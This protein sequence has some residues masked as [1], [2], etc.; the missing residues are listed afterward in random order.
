MHILP[1]QPAVSAPME[2]SGC[3]HGF[4]P[5]SAYRVAAR[6]ECANAKCLLCLPER[7]EVEISGTRSGGGR[8]RLQESL[9]GRPSMRL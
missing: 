2:V 7:S 6:A 1:L 3:S 8:K 4:G 9:G 5:H